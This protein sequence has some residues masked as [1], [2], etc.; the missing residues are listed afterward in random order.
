[1]YYDQI[2]D[3]N[4]VIVE[5]MVQFLETAVPGSQHNV[6]VTV[7]YGMDGIDYLN[8]VNINATAP[9]PLV[10]NAVSRITGVQSK[11]PQTKRFRC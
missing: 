9:E 5:I 3:N 7:D 2:F 6:L 10:F 11:R 1:M 4:T 8:S